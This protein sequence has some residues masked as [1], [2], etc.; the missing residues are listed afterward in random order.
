MSSKIQPQKPQ[1]PPNPNESYTGPRTNLQHHY[2]V[3]KKGGSPEQQPPPI[4]PAYDEWKRKNRAVI[5]KPEKPTYGELFPPKKQEGGR[6]RRRKGRKSKRAKRSHKKT[7]RAHKKSKS[8]RK[9]H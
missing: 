6:T 2:P 9:R 7:R 1:K 3:N 4:K 5:Q 8:H